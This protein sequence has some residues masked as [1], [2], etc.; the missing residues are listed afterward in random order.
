[1]KRVALPTMTLFLLAVGPPISAGQQQGPMPEPRATRDIDATAPP[2]SLTVDQAVRIVLESHPAI[3]EAR[4]GVAV[5]SAR[6]AST[7]SALYP[8]VDA[9]GLYSHLGPVP[10]LEFQDRS[11]TLYPSNNYNASVTLRQTVYDAGKREIEV[12]VARSVEGTVQENVELV[13]SELAYRT[14]GAFNAILF[15]QQN[16]E[17]QDQELQ[18]LNEHLVVTQEKVRSGAATDFEV[19]TTRVRIADVQSRRVDVASSLESRRIELRQLLGLGPGAPLGLLGEFEEGPPGLDVDSLV[20]L[21]MDQRPEVRMARGAEGTA[22]VRTRLASVGD[23]PSVSV[24]LTVGAK[25]G[26]IPHL[27]ALKP[28]WVAGMS[29]DFPLFNGYR[30]RSQVEESQA[31]L[32]QA[33]ANIQA[34]ERELVTQVRQAVASVQAS[35]DKIRAA[36][37]QVQQAEAALALANTR[38][39]AGVITNLDV[40]DAQTSLSEAR[41]M[42]L[43]ARYDLTRNRY[44][45]RRAVGDAGW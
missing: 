36:Q 35:E 41:L 43:S 33:R 39:E 12:D 23:K 24:N 42:E 31:S 34:L 20:N 4:Q 22:Q 45:L 3:D 29:V 17:V 1:M 9:T 26:Y 37:M 25:N 14:I 10:S 8:S 6:V 2:D 27:N 13:R 44:A 16:L 19:L 32:N 40:L 15:L 28:N 38:Y 11:I 30:T 7:R 5:S 18:A 21:A